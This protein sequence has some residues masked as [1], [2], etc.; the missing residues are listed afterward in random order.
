MAGFDPNQPRDEEGKWVKAEN[1]ARKMAGL[2]DQYSLEDFKDYYFH[3]STETGTEKI[4]ESGYI[5][6]GMDNWSPRPYT[7]FWFDNS[8]PFVVFA[9]PKK[10]LRDFHTTLTTK[11]A[12]NLQNLD[13]EDLKILVYD[14]KTKKFSDYKK[15]E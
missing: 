1:A 5:R 10:L 7:A 9:A 4:L 13:L 14:P 11:V 8:K 15:E 2:A 12:S 3:R 6:A